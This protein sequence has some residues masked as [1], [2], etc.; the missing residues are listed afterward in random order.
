MTEDAE[1]NKK[2]DE[3]FRETVEVRNNLESYSNSLRTQLD[4]KNVSMRMKAAD[5]KLIS[6]ALR[7]ALKWLRDN[8]NATKK[9][10]KKQLRTLRK[11]AVPIINKAFGRK[12]DFDLT[13]DDD[14]DD[15]EEVKKS[16]PKVEVKEETISVIEEKPEEKKT[17]QPKTEE[18]KKDEL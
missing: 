11:V 3:E 16:E 5:R 4:D 9:E 15:E 18:K 17:E 1:K 2:E 7:K 13:L 12:E 8:E 10:Y 6:K 14:D